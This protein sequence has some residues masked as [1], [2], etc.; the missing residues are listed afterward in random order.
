M[1]NQKNKN[2]FRILLALKI[3][4]KALR[5]K[6]TEIIKLNDSNNNPYEIWNFLKTNYPK[7]KSNKF[8]KTFV[9]PLKDYFEAKTIGPSLPV[10]NNL[11]IFDITGCYQIARNMLS[12][13]IEDLFFYEKIRDIRNK[14]FLSP[15]EI[16]NDEY[17]IVLADL[18]KIINFFCENADL[19]KEYEEQIKLIEENKDFDEDLISRTLSKQSS[20]SIYVKFII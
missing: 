20:S 1:A 9:L 18:K 11:D 17:D 15:Y 19:K 6:L 16:E 7:Y 3:A 13:E 4:H 8:M 12:K 14:F 10:P 2:A 5:F